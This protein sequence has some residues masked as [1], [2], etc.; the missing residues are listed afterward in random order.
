MMWFDRNHPDVVYA[1]KRSETHILC[2]GRT[3]EINPDVVMD[4]CQMPFKDETFNLVV[5]DPP[6]LSK[7]G[8]NAYMAKKY[9]VLSYHW[10]DDIRDGL[11]ECMRVL[12]TDGV[13]I[14]KWNQSEIR[15]HQI[16]DLLPAKPLFGHTSGKGGLT[17]WMTFMKGDAA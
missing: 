13:L 3:L 5:F 16:M 11:A 17:I 15:V 7:L 9:G 6:H 1:D 4:F 10:R 8:Q 2:D 12:K 14:F